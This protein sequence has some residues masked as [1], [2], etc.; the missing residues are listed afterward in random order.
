MKYIDKE[1]NI[2]SAGML[3]TNGAGLTKTV[4]DLGDGVLGVSAVN[5]TFQKNHP[6]VVDEEYYPL[7]PTATRHEWKVVK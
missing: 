3:I 1:G 4:V 2:I 7:T 5:E 6:Y